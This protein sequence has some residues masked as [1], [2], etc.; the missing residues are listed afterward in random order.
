L[1]DFWITHNFIHVAVSIE[2]M[3]HLL[4]DVM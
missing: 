4:C 1:E 3:L 2:T